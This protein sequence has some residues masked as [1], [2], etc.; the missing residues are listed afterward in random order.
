MK[1][2]SLDNST[3]ST[4]YAIGVD[5]KLESHGCITA[6]SKDVIKRIIKMRDQLS[7]IIKDNKIDKIV[8][9]EVRPQYNSHT[10]K[11]LMWLQAVIV[12]AAYQ[13]NA[14]IQFEF[15]QAVQW[16]A[17]LKIKQGRGVKRQALKPQDIQYVE[18]KYN[19]KV[20]DDE[21]DAICIF[22]AYWQKFDNELNWGD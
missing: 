4:G 2:L 8:M 12:V 5:G 20:N 9:Q 10:N 16:R 6:S 18:D 3:K 22:D 13:I 1:I 11:V 21:A 15:I 7:K 14:K 19:I 17:A